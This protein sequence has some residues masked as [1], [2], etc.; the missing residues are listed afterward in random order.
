MRRTSRRTRQQN[1][2]YKDTPEK[3]NN[4]T[5]SNIPE[6]VLILS[7]NS[8]SSLSCD[9]ISTEKNNLEHESVNE[10]EINNESNSQSSSS[11]N[12]S[13][14]SFNEIKKEFQKKKKALQ[15]KVTNKIAILD[16]A[17]KVANTQ[18][19]SSSLALGMICIK[20][21]DSAREMLLKLCIGGEVEVRLSFYL[22]YLMC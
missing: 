6:H 4:C 16:L 10:D 21:K 15:R 1:S 19:I 17:I 22:C 12:S 3:E 8:S 13:E 2:W 9:K 7:S 18:D 14:P 11:R 20:G 5:D